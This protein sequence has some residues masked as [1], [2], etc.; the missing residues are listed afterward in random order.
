VDQAGLI[1][2][3]GVRPGQQ[4]QIR[5]GDVTPCG[6]RRIKIELAEAVRRDLAAAVPGDDA[7]GEAAFERIRR[8]AR[9]HSAWYQL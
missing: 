2:A 6:L 3:C 1:E 7:H 9:R 8:L 5:G 4:R